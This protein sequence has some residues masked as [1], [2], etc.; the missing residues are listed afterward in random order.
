M[1]GSSTS[2]DSNSTRLYFAYGSNLSREQMRARCPGAAPVAA[3][4]LPG[5]RLAFVGERTQRWGRGGVAT[6]VPQAGECV[7]GALYR[8]NREDELALDGF[9]GVAGGAYRRELRL[10][11]GDGEPV[12][13]YVANAGL[14]AE[15][16]PNAKYLAV[17]R[18]GFVDWGLPLAALDGLS[19]Y[20]AEE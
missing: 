8:L 20:P 13:V 15:N 16:Q 10:F 18:Q 1:P 12:L 7:H 4:T 2:D 14:D 17:I 19:A 3:Q 5:F 9:E 11:A 6:V